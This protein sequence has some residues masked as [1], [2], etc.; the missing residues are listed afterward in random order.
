[1]AVVKYQTRLKEP[2]RGLCSSWLASLSPEQGNPR[3]WGWREYRLKH[4]SS[5]VSS[6]T[7]DQAPV[8]SSAL[9]FDF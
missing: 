4:L 7:G 8:S 5:P 3:F 2:R 1:M 6:V 9:S